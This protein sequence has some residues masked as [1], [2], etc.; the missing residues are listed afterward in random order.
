MTGG[1]A[2]GDP[3]QLVYWG[4]SLGG[5]MGNALMGYEPDITRAVLGVPGGEWSLM[6]QRSSQWPQFKLLLGGSYPDYLDVQLLLALAQMRFD[7][8]DPITTAPRTILDPLPGSPKKQILI[9][10][11]VADSQVPNLSTDIVARTEG[12]PLLGPSS[13]QAWGLPETMAPQPS[14]LVCWDI[15]AMPIPGDTNTTPTVDN[16]AHGGIHS[17]PK[18]QAQLDHFLRQGEIIWTCD[19]P[20]DP[21]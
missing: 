6:I 9:H 17:L 4:I 10:L 5:I 7:F 18:L 2:L 21:Q 20:C 1:A 8:A 19:G 16:G 12:I 15:H 11:A 14:G 13:R 3:T